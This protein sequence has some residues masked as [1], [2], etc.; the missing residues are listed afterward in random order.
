MPARVQAGER[1]VQSA[2][3]D[4]KSA[5]EQ[6]ATYSA[7]LVQQQAQVASANEALLAAK[8]ALEGARSEAAHLRTE[9]EVAKVRCGGGD[10]GG[11]PWHLPHAPAL[12]LPSLAASA[13]AGAI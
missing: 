9:N 4:V 5:Q 7:L 6:A 10:R 2:L 3:N 8:A 1:Q 11:G 12:I 13:C